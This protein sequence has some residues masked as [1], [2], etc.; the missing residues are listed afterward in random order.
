MKGGFVILLLLVACFVMHWWDSLTPSSGGSGTVIFPVENSGNA[1]NLQNSPNAN[2]TQN[3]NRPPAPSIVSADP[4]FVNEPDTFQ[5]IPV[6]KTQFHIQIGNPGEANNFPI[7]YHIPTPYLV[8]TPDAVQDGNVELLTA[9]GPIFCKS[10]RFTF[11]TKDKVDESQVT[12]LLAQP[13]NK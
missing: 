5:G 6:Y 11:R 12:F 13:N 4:V 10:Y 3:V 8:G 2:V 1:L 9:N 7:S